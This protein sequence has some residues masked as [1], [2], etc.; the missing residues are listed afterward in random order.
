MVSTGSCHALPHVSESANPVP[1][2]TEVHPYADTVGM[3]LLWYYAIS[4][5]L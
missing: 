4:G 5:L 2:L 1:T 3:W